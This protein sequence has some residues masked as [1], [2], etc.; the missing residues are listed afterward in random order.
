MSAETHN[1][2]ARLHWEKTTV[3]EMAVIAAFFLN[4]HY[5]LGAQGSTFHRSRVISFTPYNNSSGI[6]RSLH[7]TEKGTGLQPYVTCLKLPS[8]MAE[9][10]FKPP[11]IRLQ[12]KF[13]ESS[14]EFCV[15]CFL[16]S[17]YL[18]HSAWTLSSE[19]IAE[20]Q[21]HYTPVLLRSTKRTSVSFRCIVTTWWQSLDPQYL[22]RPLSIF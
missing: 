22:P 4:V 10:R 1:S 9:K 20:E 13:S 12:N 3:T 15:S 7:F 8:W 17:L 19:R 14:D 6:H 5:F 21:N 18:P 16:V 2:R 11:P